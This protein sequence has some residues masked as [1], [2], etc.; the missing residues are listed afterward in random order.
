MKTWR[1]QITETYNIQKTKKW[2]KLYWII[3]LHDTI[4]TGTY[5]KFNEGAIIYPYAKET[6]DYLY[7]HKIHQ[8]ILWTSSHDDAIDNILKRFD[9][10][11]NYHH[12]NP[13]CPNTSICNFDRKL[14]FNFILDDKALF[15]PNND[16][17]EIYNVLRELDNEV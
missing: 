11:F 12:I 2:N 17:V 14:Y 13:E 4:I 9:I 5:N 6:L 1:Q 10:R 7:S 3:D 16:W 8:S 15:D